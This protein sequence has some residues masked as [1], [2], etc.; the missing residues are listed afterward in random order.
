MIIPTSMS[1]AAPLSMEHE[2]VM[3][4]KVKCQSGSGPRVRKTTFNQSGVM[5][6]WLL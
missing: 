2:Q 5:G 3:S 6:Y 4:T 1:I